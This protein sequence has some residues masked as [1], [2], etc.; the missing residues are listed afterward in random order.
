MNK[1]TLLD[2]IRGTDKPYAET[3]KGWREWEAEAYY[4]HPVRFW[5]VENLFESI[6]DLI[7][8]PIKK[9]Y[10]AKYYIVNRWIDQSHSLVAHPKHIKPG[11]WQDLDYR[12]LHCL[13]DELVDFVEV[14]KAYAN[15]RWDS[16][17]IGDLKWW[18]GGR[19]RTR[20]WRSAESG[21]D[22]L[23]WESELSEEAPSSQAEAAKE[24]LFLYDW[25]VNVRPQ[26][27]D[28][29]EVSGW[30]AYCD[31]YRDEDLFA[32]FDEDN[33]GVDTKPMLDKMRDLEEQYDSEDTEMLIRLIKIRGYLWT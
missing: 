7:Q 15:Y 11:N 17:K 3:S 9:I 31:T 23:K 5:I 32:M 22:Y 4:K 29:M 12:I 33:D 1:R 16:D 10:N 27:A 18:Q 28:P 19:W 2:R 6:V 21:L 25:W 8:W 20:T 26:R 24:I 30:S 13:F 14:E